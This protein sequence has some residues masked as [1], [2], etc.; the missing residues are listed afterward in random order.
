MIKK[1]L[2]QSL[3]RFDFNMDSIHLYFSTSVCND[4]PYKR[5]CFTKT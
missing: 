1:K 5:P 4:E 2:H 3:D